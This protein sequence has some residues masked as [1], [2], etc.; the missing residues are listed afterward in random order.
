MQFTTHIFV[1]IHEA[2]EIRKKFL[3]IIK[4]NILES[5][6]KAVHQ[7]TEKHKDI[8]ILLKKYFTAGVTPEF[9]TNPKDGDTLKG[10]SVFFSEI[11]KCYSQ[12]S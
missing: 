3:S 7:M 12:L 9:A 5:I 4:L 11:L 8:Q 6:L 2:K 10:Q 1:V